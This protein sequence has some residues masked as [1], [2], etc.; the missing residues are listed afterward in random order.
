MSAQET[1]KEVLQG[2]NLVH[3]S[4][5]DPNGVPCVRGVDFAASKVG[6]NI[7][8]FITHKDSRKVQQIKSNN[9]IGFAIDHDCPSWEDLQ[10]LKYIK[11]NGN[12]SLVENPQEMQQVR[13]LMMQKFPF[14]EN[15]PGDPQDFVA[16][17][18]E[19]KDVLV[20]DNTIS[21]GNTETVTY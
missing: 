9:A 13:G 16:V 8:Y 14:L 12:A 6:E 10:Q 7:I 21:F 5:I 11:G 3:I 1:I 4:T 2:H 17:K 19:L 20:T 15:L 18:V